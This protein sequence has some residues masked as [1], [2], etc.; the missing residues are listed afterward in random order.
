MVM[1]DDLPLLESFRINDKS[2]IESFVLNGFKNIELKMLNECRMFLRVTFLS[3][4]ATAD[5]L[6]IE[7]W[8]WRGFKS[9]LTINQYIW[10]R[11]PE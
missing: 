9:S 8:A 3:E 10:P 1:H 7:G 2:I 5:G 6:M 4:I 11:S